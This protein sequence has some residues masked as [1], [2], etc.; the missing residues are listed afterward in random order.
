MQRRHTDGLDD[1]L[2]QRKI[3]VF[4]KT[5]PL[6][7][8]W[9]SCSI[10]S[11]NSSKSLL[12][13]F[14]HPFTVCLFQASSPLVFLP[15]VMKI[16]GVRRQTVSKEDFRKTIL[17]MACLR[18]LS[19]TLNGF[20][21]LR[22]PVSYVHTVKATQP[23]MTVL[24]ALVLLGEYPTWKQV[25]SLIPIVAGVMLASLTEV[26]FDLIGALCAV[27]SA[28]TTGVQNV[29]SK[30]ILNKRTIDYYN[31]LYSTAYTGSVLLFGVWLCS[32]GYTML[33]EN[34]PRKYDISFSVLMYSLS[35]VGF[36]NFVQAVVAFKII[37]MISPLSYAIANATKRIFVISAAVFVFRNPV[38]VWN[39]VGMLL[40][41][42]GIFCYN[43]A[44]LHSAKY[45]KKSH[46][47]RHKG[48]G[49][50][51]SYVIYK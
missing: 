49:H 14:P 12:Q 47:P 48:D 43:M 13:I 31:L 17:P 46:L 23:I 8:V 50:A 51:D 24:V 45:G 5:L 44:K 4:F 40:A 37:S 11:N 42:F 29:V 35:I 2:A 18:V 30:K 34:I 28:M 3:Q 19:T 33:T 6:L 22:I 38:T 41:L 36:A 16:N 39:V 32:D 25:I 10:I 27:F 15:V 7:F 1:G 26:E 21:V 20:S 9:Y